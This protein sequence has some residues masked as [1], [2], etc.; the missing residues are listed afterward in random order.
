M[1]YREWAAGK[2]M[3]GLISGLI[4]VREDAIHHCIEI[5]TGQQVIGMAIRYADE[6]IAGLKK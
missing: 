6:L 2:A 5:P 3:D 1:S 4:R